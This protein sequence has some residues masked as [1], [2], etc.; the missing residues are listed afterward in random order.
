MLQHD[1]I[2]TKH[3]LSLIDYLTVLQDG[4]DVYAVNVHGVGFECL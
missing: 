2:N 4:Y 3:I 1:F